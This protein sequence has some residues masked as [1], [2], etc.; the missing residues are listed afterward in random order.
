MHLC[1]LSDGIAEHTRRWTTYFAS[2]SHEV[3]LITLNP[4]VLD[5]YD[6]VRVHIVKK[7]FPGSDLLSRFRNYPTV[8]REVRQIL[9]TVKPDVLHAHS[10]GQYA[11]IS[12]LTGFHPYVVTP[13]G[14]DLLIDAKKSRMNRII[15][16]RSLRKANMVTCDA[17]HI[18]TEMV[19]MGIPEERIHLVIFGVDMRRFDAQID[20]S[21][22]R[23]RYDLGDDP[24][25]ISTRTLNPVHDVA[26]FI[27]AIPF[28]H[29]ACP[30]ARFVVTG[31]GK[32]REQL[33]S[34]ARSLGIASIVNF[35]GYLTEDT[36]I[37][38]LKTADVYV[39][40]S[41]SDAGLSVSTAEA[42]ACELP[43]VVT[44]N[45]DNREWVTS[46]TGGYIVANG[47]SDAIATRVIDLLQDSTK[48]QAFGAYNR[49]VIIERC[50]YETEMS[51]METL[52]LEL[53]QRI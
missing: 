46:D 6:P 19:R 44:D 1:F 52:Y 36:M 29:A 27:Q 22:L 21:E 32:D 39:S 42:M 23:V 43:V 47:A 38:W 2:K 9:N 40:T 53:S 48:R 33:E 26:T 35:V 41:L 31:D 10:A 11:W 49:D 18:Q 24:V 34:L 3:D 50:N 16:T 30:E 25:V 37:Q 17:D 5:G 12:M 4:N 51:H 14:T 8:I 45:G 20:D 28:I 15:T 13:W 7:P